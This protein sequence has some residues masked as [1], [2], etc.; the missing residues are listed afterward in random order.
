MPLRHGSRRRRH[1][2]EPRARVVRRR[3]RSRSRGRGGT[4]ASGAISPSTSTGHRSGAASERRQRVGADQ[5]ATLDHDEVVAD[6]LDLAQEMRGHQDRDPELGADPPDEVEHLVAARRIEPVRRL[7]E[8]HELR[9]VNERLGELDP[10]AHPGRVPAHL[11]IALLEQADVA[12]RF[13]R[14]LARGSA[15]QPVDLGHVA[16]ELGGADLERQAVVLRHVADQPPHREP[17]GGDVEPEHLGAAPR[18]ARRARA[19]S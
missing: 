13:G 9:V 3:R 7:V 16:D 2:R 14:A 8:E 17:F 6:P 19:G 11:S 1:R 5:P 15:R 10:L 12:K 4:S 18:S